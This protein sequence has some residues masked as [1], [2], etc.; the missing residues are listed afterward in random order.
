MGLL[1]DFDASV[2][3]CAT[4]DNHSWPKQWLR[5]PS[6]VLPGTPHFLSLAAPFYARATKCVANVGQPPSFQFKKKT[7]KNSRYALAN[8]DK[9]SYSD[10]LGASSGWRLFKQQRLSKV[11]EA[12]Q[13]SASCR[14]TN[15]TFCPHL[16][17]NLVF[18]FHDNVNS[19]NPIYSEPVR[20]FSNWIIISCSAAVAYQPTFTSL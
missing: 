14:R 1:S 20:P 10:L 12:L 9:L 11:A 4:Q 3:I 2:S 8:N 6:P 19:V 16:N 7:K 5:C 13:R 18:V 17:R 15:K